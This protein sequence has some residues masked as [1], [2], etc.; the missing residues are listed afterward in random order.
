MT[1]QTPLPDELTHAARQLAKRF[2]HQY[3]ERG[4]SFESLKKSHMGMGCL[5]ER[6][7]IGGWMNGKSYS[8]DF[9]LV[10]KADGREANVAFKLRDIFREVRGEIQSARDV[11]DFRLEPG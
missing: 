3:V 5:K 4:D 2:I 11:D 9:I 7:Q 8:T 6:V 10:S 1:S